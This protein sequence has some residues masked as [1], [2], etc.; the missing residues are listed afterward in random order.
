[1]DGR[2]GDITTQHSMSFF[3][4]SP[5]LFVHNVFYLPPNAARMH[6]GEVYI[7]FCGPYTFGFPYCTAESQPRVIDWGFG[8]DR[9][10]R[11]KNCWHH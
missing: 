11:G 3:L 7:P 5:G 6:S 4:D 10:L 1:M 2:K 8:N 9:D